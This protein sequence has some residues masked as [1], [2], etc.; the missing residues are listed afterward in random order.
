[1]EALDERE[2]VDLADTR[3]QAIVFEIVKG[4]KLAP[5]RIAT[6]ASEALEPGEGTSAKLALE[7]M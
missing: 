2:L 5:E 4:G 7:A 1:V 3:A 6:R